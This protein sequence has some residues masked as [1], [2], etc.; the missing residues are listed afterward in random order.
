MNISSKMKLVI[1]TPFYET[2]GFSPYISSL[3]KSVVFLSRAGFLFDYWE[4]AGD[5]YIDRARNRITNIFMK[6]DYTHLLFVDSDHAWDLQ[7][8]INILEHDV[9][10][11]GAAYPAKNAWNIWTCC[12]NTEKGYEK[13]FDDSGKLTHVGP[14]VNGPDGLISAQ[15][16]ATGFMKIRR[17]VFLKLAD[18]QPDNFY[19][20]NGEKIY[21]FFGRIPPLG[22]DTSFCQ[23]WRDIGGELWVE[24]N[25][26]ISHYGTTNYSG[27]FAE[28]LKS[29]PL[30]RRV[31]N[32][33]G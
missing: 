22:E 29:M 24:P 32:V 33:A 16:V 18:K 10:I 17:E 27:N 25:C 4:A 1:C 7:S 2:K 13:T 8:L 23:R 9:D 28:Y 6:S 3:V 19:I 11:V 26:N 31:A 30:A 20:E 12:I 5:S 15:F 21:N 14:P